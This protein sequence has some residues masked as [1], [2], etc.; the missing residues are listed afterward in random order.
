M[1][2]R[3]GA[4]RLAL[5][6]S[7]AHKAREWEALL[8]GWHVQ[9]LD[10]SGAPAESAETFAE[11]A[12]GKALYGTG[13]APAGAWV[14]GEDSGLVVDALDGAP[15]VRSARYAGVGATDADNVVRLLASLENTTER[16]AHFECSVAC[17]SPSGEQFETSGVLRGRI[18]ALARGGEGFGYD[19]VF[20]PDGESQA[21]AELGAEWKRRASH[22]AL[23]A[24]NL[25][26]WLVGSASDDSG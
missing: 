20:V 26:D 24:Q 14:L 12:L 13:L 4:L 25:L 8:P 2:A 10:M 3:G 15:G 23:A 18:A 1:S 5:A 6:S 17:V 16:R 9:T 7:N 19:P 21:V 11:N 22:R